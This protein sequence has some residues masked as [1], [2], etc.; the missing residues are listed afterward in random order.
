MLV[1]ICIDRKS[2]AVESNVMEMHYI[3]CCSEYSWLFYI[4]ECL[5][6]ASAPSFPLHLYALSS[7]GSL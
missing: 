2:C 1:Y 3:S 7:V 5:A 4:P 6:I